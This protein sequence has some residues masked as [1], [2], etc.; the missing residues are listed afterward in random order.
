MNKA[1]LGSLPKNCDQFNA[2]QLKPFPAYS[3]E[4]GL[5]VKYFTML[6]CIIG[7]RQQQRTAAFTAMIP[8][9]NVD[10]ILNYMK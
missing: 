9:N 2:T 8:E 4:A 1:N 6:L 5:E 3:L 10:K 7:I